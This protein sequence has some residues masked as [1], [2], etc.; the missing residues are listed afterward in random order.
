MAAV[1]NQK[2]T[3]SNRKQEEDEDKFKTFVFFLFE[4]SKLLRWFRE[5]R[6]GEFWLRSDF[7]SPDSLER[8]NQ[9]GSVTTEK[10]GKN[11]SCR[12]PSGLERRGGS[13]F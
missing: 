7:L 11:R 8:P 9:T 10:G 4:Y 1:R 2:K 3:D 13:R 6:L 5:S 12:A